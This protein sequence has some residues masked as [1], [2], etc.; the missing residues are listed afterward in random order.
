MQMSRV[1]CGCELAS[2]TVIKKIGR[3]T[4]H[5]AQDAKDIV[6]VPRRM[7][8][9]PF[10]PGNNNIIVLADTYQEVR[11]VRIQ[12][13]SGTLQA[14]RREEPSGDEKDHGPATKFNTRA[15][16]ESALL[17]QAISL[18]KRFVMLPRC[19]HTSQILILTYR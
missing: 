2:R 10:R 14:S 6:I 12:C 4:S 11:V 13:G 7:Y 8:R 3:S 1:G 9:D 5:S 15:A 18:R 17:L 16:C 19:S